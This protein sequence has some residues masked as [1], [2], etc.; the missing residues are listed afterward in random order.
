MNDDDDD[1]FYM[2]FTVYIMLDVHKKIKI[3]TI[4]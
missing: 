2:K 4:K 1:N 3:I